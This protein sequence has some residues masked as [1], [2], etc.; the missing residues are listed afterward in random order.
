MWGLH[1]SSVNPQV[2]ASWFLCFFW[3]PKKSKMLVALKQRVLN[4]QAKETTSAWSCFKEG[5][6]TSWWSHVS[7]DKFQVSQSRID[8]GKFHREQK[9]PALCWEPPEMAVKSKGNLHEKCPKHLGLGMSSSIC[10]DWRYF[11]PNFSISEVMKKPRDSK[12][13]SPVIVLHGETWILKEWDAWILKR[14]TL[15]KVL[16]KWNDESCEI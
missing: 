1:G 11:D 8:R 13:R 4:F 6:E 14:W 15:E 5:F 10:R 7:V 2:L 12:Y 3:W 9:D 16:G